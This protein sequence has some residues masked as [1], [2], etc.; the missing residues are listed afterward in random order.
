MTLRIKDWDRHFENAES[1]KR[2][3]LAFVLIPNRQGSF[4]CEMM[5]EEDGLEL[6]AI[7]VQLLA[8][9]SCTKPKSRRG[10]LVMGNGRPHDARSLAMVL[11]IPQEKLERAIPFFLN[12]GRLESSGDFLN[13]S[14]SVGKKSGDKQ[15]N[16]RST[17]PSERKKE[18]KKEGRKG[19]SCPPKP[20]PTAPLSE[21]P[22]AQDS[23]DLAARVVDTWNAVARAPA[24]P[25]DYHAT[26]EIIAASSDLRHIRR[27]ME[28]FSADTAPKA[29]PLSTFARQVGE[30]LSKAGKPHDPEEAERQAAEYRR[31]IEEAEKAAAPPPADLWERIKGTKEEASA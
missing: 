10:E 2:D 17:S 31:K 30:W 15:E 28:R 6:Y 29:L 1:R 9:A 22:P 14:Q 8:V 25:G 12:S 7:W 24:A 20:P 27:A 5:L 19:A 18:R 21:A 16:D 13:D 26:A 23:D 4:Y 3:R 11:R